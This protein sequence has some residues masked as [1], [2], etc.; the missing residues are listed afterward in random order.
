[1]SARRDVKP[2]TYLRVCLLAHKEPSQHSE[3][4][5]LIYLLGDLLERRDEERFNEVEW[6]RVDKLIRCS[7]HPNHLAREVCQVLSGRIL[8][9]LSEKCH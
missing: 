8:H 4:E 7:D 2:Y 1:M 6:R 9:D 5:F 3:C